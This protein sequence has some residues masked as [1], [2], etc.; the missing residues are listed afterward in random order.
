MR[1]SQQPS[2][3]TMNIGPQVQALTGRDLE[4][5][6]GAMS[7]LPL[8]LVA[9]LMYVP[10]RQGQGSPACLCRALQRGGWEKAGHVRRCGSGTGSWG[11][12]ACRALRWLSA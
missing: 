2:T 8:G 9:P 7:C 11:A 10:L 12:L 4:D 5:L 3:L 6:P 1:L